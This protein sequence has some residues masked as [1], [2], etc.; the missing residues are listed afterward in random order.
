[1]FN[2]A[3]RELKYVLSYPRFSDTFKN[4]LKS[5]FE[6]E[7]CKLSFF[8]WH[9]RFLIQIVWF[10]TG[11]YTNVYPP[12]LVFLSWVNARFKK[13][14]VGTRR[15]PSTTPLVMLLVEKSLLMINELNK[16]LFFCY[17]YELLGVWFMNRKCILVLLKI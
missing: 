5:W 11:R 10:E 8:K 16:R 14:K 9:N 4:Y 12:G 2:V 3:I 13:F 17:Y 15:V 7:L 1:M 6:G